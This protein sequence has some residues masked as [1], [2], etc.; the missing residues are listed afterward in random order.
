MLDLDMKEFSFKPSPA[1]ESLWRENKY[2]PEIQ[3][4]GKQYVV[5]SSCTT[6]DEAMAVARDKVCQMKAA[7]LKAGHQLVANCK[8]A[9]E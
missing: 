5:G 2:T 7:M 4:D 6:Y 9:K 8:L 3:F 1:V